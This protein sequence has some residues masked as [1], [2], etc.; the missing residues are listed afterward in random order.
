MPNKKSPRSLLRNTLNLLHLDVTRNLAYD[1]LTRQIMRQVIKKDTN[2]ID[3]GCH[4]GEMLDLILTLAPEGTHY[5]FEPLP[6]MFENLQARYNGQTRVF[7]YALADYEGVSEFQ[8]IRND[9][10]YSGLKKRSYDIKDP[11]IEVIEVPVRRLDDLIP[12]DVTVGF[13]KIDV[14]GGE[15][16]VLRGAKKMIIRNKPIIIFECGLGAS[17]FYDTE[18]E[19][20]YRFLVNETGLCISLLKSYARKG[21]PLDE[22]QFVSVY[23]S[24]K[25]WYFVAHPC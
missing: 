19:A 23:R 12:A 17:E 7:P 21:K 2:C 11:D 4:K 15:F 25:E 13:L 18:P 10:A 16:G 5:A 24:N 14:E 3:V 1:R 9:P 8:F 20:L 6:D 22:D